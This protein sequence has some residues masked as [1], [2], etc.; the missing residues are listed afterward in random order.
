MEE[1][2]L[3]CDANVSVRL[4]GEIKLGKKVEIKNMNSVRN[5]QRAIEFEFKRQTSLLEKGEEII[6]ET[7]T[8]DAALGETFSMR[9]KEELNDYRYFPDPDISPVVVSD[10]WL[11]DIKSTMPTLPN[12]LFEKYTTQYGL[13][14]YDATVLTDTKEIAQYF[15]ALCNSSKN[16]KSA[17]NWLMVNIKSYLNESRITI[18]QFPVNASSLASLINLV[19]GGQVSHTAAAKNIFPE[20]I[21]NPTTSPL[22]IA[23]QLNLILE[24][25]SSSIEKII[26]EALKAFPDKVIEYKKGKKGIIGMFM[27]EVMKRSGGKADPKI[28]NKILEEKLK[29]L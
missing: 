6:S 7:R 3:R 15:E 12:E 17:S 20:L 10:E 25:D 18:S 27:G 8:F 4:K 9:T 19:D 23:Q 22:L 1:G 5:V 2:S 16:F 26:D 28:S 13:P 21:K 14:D 29:S 11:A 24:N